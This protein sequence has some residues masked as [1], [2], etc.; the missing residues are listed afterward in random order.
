[1]EKKT[2]VNDSSTNLFKEIIA[3]H[4]HLDPPNVK[5]W[6]PVLCKVCNDHGKKGKR[7]AFIFTTHGGTYNCFNC[8]HVAVYEPSDNKTP[9]KPMIIVFDSFG[10]VKSDWAKLS[11]DALTSEYTQI[12]QVYQSIEPDEISLLPFFYRL[13]DDIND[14][15]CQ[16]SIE[17][18]N[19]RRIDWQSYPFYCVKQDSHPMNSRWYGRLIIP[20]Y[21][22]N[23]LIFY[24]GRDL[25]DIHQKKYLSASVPR[26]NVLYGYNELM[27]YSTDPVYVVEGWFDA[28]M[29]NG[30]AVFGNKLTKP[31]IQWLNKSRRPKIVIPDRLGSG[32]ILA[33]QAIELGWSVST[34]DKYDDCKDVNES[35]TKHGLLYTMRTISQ[36][37][38]SGNIAKVAT[39]LYC[40]R[41]Q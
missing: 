14:D 36:N 35:I 3:Q 23:K 32:Y 5:G 25:T 26:D 10:V 22:D 24:Q 41:N 1:M 21:K 15:W 40:K 37:T 13:N 20:I 17:Y 30:V 8:G 11:L 4:I 38:V 7:A 33:E 16:Y 2:P 6:Y 34:L 39:K 19:H 29:I 18:L 31:Q 28:Y 9:S 27:N 12:V